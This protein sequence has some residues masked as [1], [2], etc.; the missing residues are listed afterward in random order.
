[1]TQ[2]IS[3]YNMLKR[4]GNTVSCLI[5]G[6]NPH[7]EIPEFVKQQIDVEIVA[8]DCPGFV[9]DSK[10]K[11]VKLIPSVLQTFLNL[12]KFIKSL[13]SIQEKVKEY[14]PDIIINFYNPLGG[15]YSFIFRPGVPLV[16]IAHQYIYLHPDYIFPEGK[17][18]DRWA[19]KLYSRFTAI[20]SLKK[21]ALSFYPLPYYEKEA[22]LAFPPLLR[23]AVFRAE[24]KTDDF[25]L[26]YLVNSGYAED[27]TQWHN[28]HPEVMLH[29]FTDNK[30][31][32]GKRDETL[33]FHGLD[34]RSFLERMANCKGLISTAGFESIC[35][36][37]YLG[38]PVFMVPV[39]GNYEQFCNAHDACKTGTGLRDERFNINR[40]VAYLQ[41]NLDT[42]EEYRTWVNSAEEKL[43][44]AL[45]IWKN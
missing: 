10:L 38:K 16:C 13:R 32:I 29:C 20:K 33:E 34:E 7:R 17:K 19:I 25:L 28:K 40:F 26:V 22:V 24:V 4:A 35:E 45:S 8:V 36:A 37:K 1:M 15:L 9:M 11:A 39:K 31:L 14:Q 42:N 41:T 2:A 5:I 21:L 3:A 44:E 12:P 43:L 18:M 27:I 23:N 6:I 30:E